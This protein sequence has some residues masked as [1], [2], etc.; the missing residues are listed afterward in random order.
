MPN[1]RD[2]RDRIKSV[3][4]TRQITRAMKLV[5]SAKLNKATQA[6]LAAQPYQR[7]L[8][9]VITRVLGA[10]GEEFSHPLLVQPDNDSVV[11]VV[12][13]SADRGLCGNFNS[14]AIKATEQECAK[15]VAAGK[16]VKVLA[17][18]KKVKVHLEKRGF[19]VIYGE[20][21]LD[22]KDYQRIADE[23][24]ARLVSDMEK[25]L[26][27]QAVLVYNQ[28]K[29]IMEQEPTATQVLPMKLDQAAKDEGT[30]SEAGAGQD[31]LFEPD[32]GAIL[33]QLLPQYL[34]TGIF[35][36]FLET[37]AGEQAKRM[38]AMD[39][40][41]RNA[42]DLIDSLRLTYNRARQAYITKELIEIVSG[43]EALN[44]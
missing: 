9:R 43:A 22:P 41:T 37:Q 33:G 35:Q 6:A 11:Y 23:L 42:S 40:A 1:L 10:V 17:Y 2:I 12:A 15:H 32:G 18:G 36:A 38:T 7:T 39:A 27:S 8:D 16:T 5:A 28:Y 26:F 21:D 14:M 24:T 31:Y 20:T 34:R 4:N 29:N 25:N 3:K 19:D 30:E 44:G 13:L